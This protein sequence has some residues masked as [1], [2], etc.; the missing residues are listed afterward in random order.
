MARQQG[1]LR[2]H[3]FAIALGERDPPV[4]FALIVEGLVS[5]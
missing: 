1:D 4:G 2:P 3:C 5:G